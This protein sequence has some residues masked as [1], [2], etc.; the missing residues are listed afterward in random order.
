MYR[1]T[2]CRYGIKNDVS[3]FHSFTQITQ[4][5]ERILGKLWYLTE[6][7][8]PQVNLEVADE[9]DREVNVKTQCWR[10]SQTN[11]M[12]LIVISVQTVLDGTRVE[13]FQI[14]ILIDETM[15]IKIFVILR[16][17]TVIIQT[18]MSSVGIEFQKKQN[19]S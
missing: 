18:F 5:Y 17:F 4:W 13:I 3:T 6:K 11:Q 19:R 7:D 10:S 12:V 16:T 8:L 9:C 15:L 14:Q 2:F 1:K